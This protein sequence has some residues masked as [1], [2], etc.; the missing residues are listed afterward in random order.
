[1]AKNEEKYIE[2][3]IQA[4]QD[5]TYIDW[6]LIVVDDHSTDTT[7]KI[8]DE[9]QNNDARI[10]LLKNKGVGKVQGTNFGYSLTKGE[11]IKCIDADDVLSPQFYEH[12]AILK[13][14]DAHYHDA[15]IVDNNLSII[16]QQVIG[17][18]FQKEK[19]EYIV[20]NIKSLPKAYWSFKRE[21]ADKIFP[22]PVD[23]PLEDEW[24]SF[25]IKKYSKSIYYI[26]KP[27]YLYRQHHGQDYGGILN[28]SSDIISYR[29]KR[30]LK[31]LEIANDKLLNNSL[32]LSDTQEFLELQ[33]SERNFLRLLSAK[34]TIKQKLKLICIFY[35]PRLTSILIRV[36]WKLLNK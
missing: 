22:M 1:M 15:N 20:K 10:T 6:E 33:V 17:S 28:Y 3:A 24:I 14:Y 9:I 25:S 8:V 31:V 21:I 2:T 32:D 30:L 11:I 16:V 7:Y 5:G 19:L 4:L 36:R 27:L 26:N 29:A 13:R 12:V 18:S 35:F 23:L 34:I